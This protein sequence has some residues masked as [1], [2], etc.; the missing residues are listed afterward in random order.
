[1]REYELNLCGGAGGA[2]GYR[3]KNKNPTRQCGELQLHTQHYTG[4]IAL[5]YNCNDHYIALHRTTLYHA[6]AHNTTAHDSTIHY[7]NCTTLQLKLQLQLHCT[8][9][10][11]LQLQLT[12]ST[13]QGSGGSFK[14]RKPMGKVG[15]CESRMEKRIH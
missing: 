2:S 14:N 6:T 5:H 3:T 1:M 13:A 12:S 4:P 7:A 10:A 8:N 11:T 15:C 9:Y